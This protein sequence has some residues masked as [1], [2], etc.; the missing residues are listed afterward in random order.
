MGT[1][2]DNEPRWKE[3]RTAL[4]RERQKRRRER[5]GKEKDAKAESKKRDR[6]RCR[7][8]RCGCRKLGLCI[9]SSHREHKKMGGNPSGSR[10][11]TA[12]LMTLCSHRHKDGKVSVDKG[13]LRWVPLSDLGADWLVRWEVDESAFLPLG[14]RVPQE[15]FWR[16]VAIETAI[17][18]AHA[19]DDWSSDRLDDLADMEL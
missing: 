13:R 4:K 18:V 8:P 11:V 2:E 16:T 6:H 9:E 19:V 1:W 3:G 7:F 15:T 14:E 5:L 10:N 12:N 17:G